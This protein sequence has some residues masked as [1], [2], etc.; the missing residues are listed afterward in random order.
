MGTTEL[1]AEQVI[2]GG[3]VLAAVLLPWTPEI[4]AALNANAGASQ[5]VAG[6]GAILVAYVLGV[7]FDR[8]ADTLTEWL[9]RCQRL[10]FVEKA[11]EQLKVSEA[12]WDPFPE[13]ALRM[14]VLATGGDLSAWVDYHR[15]R[16][17]IARALAVY[18]PF[19]TWSL[20]IGLIRLHLWPRPSLKLVW[21]AALALAIMIVAALLVAERWKVPRTNAMAS[22]RRR[23]L[24]GD[25]RA[26]RVRA[27]AI[28]W[29]HPAIWCGAGL[30]VA[31]VTVAAYI[32]LAR[33]ALGGR[34]IAPT[35]AAAA[36][37]F[38]A[39]WSWWRISWTYREYLFLAGQPPGTQT[40]TRA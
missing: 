24:F 28:I 5:L 37:A 36:L 21:P 12:A 32:E 4:V 31:A 6:A 30:V 40:V 15:S 38:A 17:R 8:L 22:D 1:Q 16:T 34:V 35:L 39:G 19:V 25:D 13:S 7:V 2:V 20:A 26:G 29:V 18:M 3:V 27:L 9:E 23:F 33:P 14:R 10:L 11:L